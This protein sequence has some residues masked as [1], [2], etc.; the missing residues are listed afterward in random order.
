M[1]SDYAW[2]KSHLRCSGL[3][4]GLLLNFRAWPPKAGRIRRV[5]V[6]MTKA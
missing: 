4:M 6:P 2:L 5:V 1:D 3:E